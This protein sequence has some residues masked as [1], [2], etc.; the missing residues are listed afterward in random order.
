MK[1]ES[2]TQNAP[3]ARACVE[4]IAPAI[5]NPGEWQSITFPWL[6]RN[7]QNNWNTVRMMSR[8]RSLHSKFTK[9]Y[10]KTKIM[11]HS[12]CECPGNG[13]GWR[14]W[15]LSFFRQCQC[16]SQA[17]GQVTAIP[18]LCF[19]RPRSHTH[20]QKRRARLGS[21]NVVLSFSLSVSYTCS[22]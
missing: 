2:R 17:W 22:E 9:L 19:P 11:L 5:M 1:N 14:C 6:P 21:I 13:K 7:L 20:A 16:R 18:P 8:R 15:S 10:I 3:Y 4:E 12:E